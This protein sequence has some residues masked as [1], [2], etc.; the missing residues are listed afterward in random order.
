MQ[1]IDIN[2]HC[3]RYLAERLNYLV[4]NHPITVFTGPRQTGKSSFLYKVLAGNWRYVTLADFDVLMQMRNDPEFYLKDGEPTIIDEAQKFPELLTVVKNL[5][6]ARQDRKFILSGTPELLLTVKKDESLTGKAAYL[7]IDPLNYGELKNLPRPRLLDTIF[8]GGTDLSGIK[9]KLDSSIA[10]NIEEFVWRGGMPG[11]IPKTGPMGIIDWRESYLETCVTNDL[12]RLS[13]I[14]DPTRFR[15]LMRGIARENGGIVNLNRLAGDI[16]LAQP[17]AHRYLNLLEAGMLVKRIPAY[18]VTKGLRM[19]KKPKTVWCDSGI[20]AHAA[21]FFSPGE[22]QNSEY[23]EGFFKAYVIT[24]LLA[25]A[26]LPVPVPKVFYWRTRKLEH[27]DLVMEQHGSLLPFQIVNTR[28]IKL[29]DTFHIQKFLQ[30][31]P[32]TILG[33]VI[34]NGL[35]VK[36]FSDNLYA[37]PLSGIF[38]E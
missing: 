27:V 31:Y 15:M 2:N 18:P 26:K 10:Y 38:A 8:Q 36:K 29:R 20:A 1:R 5:V 3:S 12:T 17:T 6:D 4:Q 24:Q 13:R 19:Y 35:I 37:I 14:E 28:N 7:E 9:V 11:M 25:L 22:L 21:G 34:Y 32:E 16:G 23:W 33:I 30:N